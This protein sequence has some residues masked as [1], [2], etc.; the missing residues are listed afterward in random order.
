MGFTNDLT[1]SVLKDG[2]HRDKKDP[3][4]SQLVAF[5]CHFFFVFLFYGPGSI[6]RTWIFLGAH[7]QCMDPG[8]IEV[9]GS[10]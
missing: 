6:L 2:I 5:V 9:F 7:P 3:P 10:V 8:S 4:F 1:P